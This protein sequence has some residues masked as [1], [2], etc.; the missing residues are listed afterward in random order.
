MQAT[1]Y[2]YQSPYSQPQPQPAASSAEPITPGTG[3][4]WLA[5]VIGL[6]GIALG[7]TIAV[8]TAV[9]W[10]DRIDGFQR[11]DVPGSGT[12][13]LEEPGDYTIYYEFALGE[14]ALDVRAEQTEVTLVAPDGSEVALDEYDSQVTYQTGDHDG[15]ALFSFT[16]DEAGEYEVTAEGESDDVLDDGPL[17]GEVA[18]GRGLGRGIVGGIL[19]ALATGL[20][21]VLV[22][23]VIAIVVGVTRSR[24]R[25]R[26]RIAFAR[27]QSAWGHSPGWGQ[28]GQPGQPPGGPYG[29]YGQYGSW[30]QPPPPPP[31]PA[32]PPPT[33]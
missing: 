13:V 2:P 8:R 23:T 15:E 19:G 9:G 14:D 31:P 25:Q 5:G 3:W 20:G 30:Q 12:V 26:R 6:V 21:G 7:I 28:P 11:V 16:A 4:Y 18:V 22:G 1:P 10:A 32:P 33:P 24:E 27:S 17:Q 29:G